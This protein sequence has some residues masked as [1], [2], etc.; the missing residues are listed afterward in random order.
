MVLK[1]TYVHNM[2]NH[3]QNMQ[4]N[5]GISDFKIICIIFKSIENPMRKICTSHF[6]DGTQALTVGLDTVKV[7]VPQ[8][9]RAHH[10]RLGHSGCTQPWCHRSQS[11]LGWSTVP[12]AHWQ[13]WWHRAQQP[14]RTWA[15]HRHWRPGLA[16]CHRGLVT[17]V[18][19]YTCLIWLW[20]QRMIGHDQMSSCSWKSTIETFVKIKWIE[21][22]Q[23]Q[24][25]RTRS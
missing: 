17:L 4:N 11:R 3:M 16:G 21:M 19:A 9:C 13:S 5:M 6:A 12:A 23:V 20:T 2:Q 22:Q 24:T 15:A 8:R 25:C 1:L 18:G 10:A 7:T 14:A